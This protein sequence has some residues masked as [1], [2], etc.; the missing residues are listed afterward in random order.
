MNYRDLV[1][2]TP[3]P[4]DPSRISFDRRCFVVVGKR[5]EGYSVVVGG[6]GYPRVFSTLDAARRFANGRPVHEERRT[7]Y[8]RIAWT[9]EELE[10]LDNPSKA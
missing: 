7:I 1:P 10:A 4:T 9:V 5:I 8:K 6:H 3:R 2:A